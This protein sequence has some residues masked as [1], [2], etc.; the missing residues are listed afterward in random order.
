MTLE[1]IAVYGLAFFLIMFLLLRL[2]LRPKASVQAHNISGI[3]VGGDSSGSISQS[4]TEAAPSS[5]SEG[6]TPHG[7][8]VLWVIGIIALL[9][10]AA[11]F[12]FDVL[13]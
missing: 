9:I 1:R 2:L 3:V 7:D 6:R 13:K 5:S 4:N 8:R 12:A 11:Q 10:A